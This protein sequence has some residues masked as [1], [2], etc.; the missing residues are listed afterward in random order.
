MSSLSENFAKKS[1]EKESQKGSERQ[2]MKF[3]ESLASCSD[4]EWDRADPAYASELINVKKKADK[5][6]VFTGP[7]SKTIERT[8]IRTDTL[9][10]NLDENAD[11]IGRMA[12][13]VAHIFLSDKTIPSVNVSIN[14]QEISNGSQTSTE[15][16]IS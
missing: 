2:E 13:A 1:K 16:R 3:G 7:S 15:P 6:T 10:E 14:L 8:I 12:S 9:S 5:V 11:A 4:T